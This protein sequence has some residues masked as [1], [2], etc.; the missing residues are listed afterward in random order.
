MPNNIDA[1]DAV[2]TMKKNFYSE[3]WAAPQNARNVGDI[4]KFHDYW[5]ALLTYFIVRT[6]DLND[7][8]S[9]E[10][11]FE[12]PDGGIWE[13]FGIFD[14]CLHVAKGISANDN[15]AVYR[16]ASGD[17][18][19]WLPGLYTEFLSTPI[20]AKCFAE[21]FN[22]YYTWGS[23]SRAGSVKNTASDNWLPHDEFL[24]KAEADM[25]DAL[26]I[27][28]KIF[29]AGNDGVLYCFHNPR[30][31]DVATVLN[32]EE[33]EVWY[34]ISSPN[35][36]AQAGSFEIFEG[37]GKHGNTAYD[38]KNPR[39]QVII[40]G[41]VIY[42]ILGKTY[43]NCFFDVLPGASMR[44]RYWHKAGTSGYTNKTGLRAKLYSQ[45]DTEAW[46]DIKTTD[47]GWTALGVPEWKYLID[48]V[49]YYWDIETKL[50]HKTLGL[51]FYAGV[52]TTGASGDRGTSTVFSSLY[53]TPYAMS[54]Q[55]EDY[56]YC[57]AYF[58]NSLYMGTGGSSGSDEGLLYKMRQ[59]DATVTT[60]Y[61]SWYYYNYEYAQYLANS[62][63]FGEYRYLHAKI[64]VDAGLITDGS[65]YE[66]G[67]FYNNDEWQCCGYLSEPNSSS[68]FNFALIVPL[69]WYSGDELTVPG[70]TTLKIM[71]QDI[72]TNIK[73]YSTVDYI[74][75]LT[76]EM[77]VDDPVTIA[78]STANV[79]D[80]LQGGI[81]ELGQAGSSTQIIALAEHNH[82]LF[83]GCNNANDSSKGI[84]YRLNQG[85]YIEEDYDLEEIID[86]VYSDEDG[87]L[88]GTH[89]QSATALKIYKREAVS[90]QID[91]TCT[92]NGFFFENMVEDDSLFPSKLMTFHITV[93][94]IADVDL[95]NIIVV[96]SL[97]TGMNHFSDNYSGVEG[98]PVA[99]FNSWSHQSVTY[100]LGTIEPGKSKTIISRCTFDA[101]FEGYLKNRAEVFAGYEGD[102]P[103]VIPQVMP[104]TIS[105]AT[106]VN[107]QQVKVTLTSGNYS[108]GVCHRLG[109]DIRFYSDANCTT[110]LSYFFESW[111]Y[112]G[113]SV[114]WVL[115]PALGTTVFYMQ[116]CNHL[117][118]TTSSLADT[119][120]FTEEFTSLDAAIWS[121]VAGSAD[122]NDGKLRINKVGGVYDLVESVS[123]HSDSL[124]IEIKAQRGY[125][126]LAEFCPIF[127]YPAT[128]GGGNTYIKLRSIASHTWTF[129][130]R[131]GGAESSENFN[132]ND[133]DYADYFVW[134]LYWNAASLRLSIDGVA[135]CPEI[136]ANIPTADLFLAFQGGNSATYSNI[137]WVR[138]RK[139]IYPELTV[140]V[141]SPL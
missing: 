32:G 115:I 69:D 138:T 139:Y 135:A 78:I 111:N 100:Q 39:E 71:V 10:E 68:V 11:V 124:I 25:N 70:G 85:D 15:Y 133:S 86:S 118:A 96:D 103:I 81:A 59:F 90:I 107:N 128:G 21:R 66:V 18:D 64:E 12:S 48:G 35:T 3:Y 56:I 46:S 120:D 83:M 130:A 119:F 79:Y 136:T 110:A 82:N 65:T 49:N 140:T 58:N 5:Y 129:Y 42:K 105:A 134:T 75:T 122:V 141:G 52:N 80:N 99:I 27:D 97:E 22:K 63:N 14:N 44:L 109:Q 31:F 108:Y 84:M 137:D 2:Y 72:N 127:M 74:G 62:N 16:S 132:D 1:V 4:I 47:A 38:L 73:Y 131:D 53:I 13:S 43:M 125:P 50:Y 87:L 24:G 29:L 112:D 40:N 60:F 106:T 37:D 88:V 102:T 54:P 67:A 104:C 121:V 101:D 61:D 91:K 116:N 17:L 28:D 20:N 95:V 55:L 23:G 77:G 33:S 41:N 94:N 113:D 57:L 126:T 89:Y 117:Q 8:T 7:D 6:N 51:F 123:K 92:Y 45:D 76:Q 34:R 30:T 98:D 9:W 93:R 36:P 114:F 19:S 26:T